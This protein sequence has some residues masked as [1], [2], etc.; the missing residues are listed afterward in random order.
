[1]SVPISTF[2]NELEKYWPKF[3]A[4]H[5]DAKWLDDDWLSMKRDM[6]RTCCV[7]VIDFAQNYAHEPRFEHQSNFFSQT[8][9]T[10]LPIVLRF[11]IEDLTN[12]DEARRAEMIAFCDK[13]ELPHV[14]V[15]THYVLSSDML[16]DSAIVQKAFDDHVFPY[17]KSVTSGIKTVCVRSD[18]CKAQFKC[19]AVQL[20]AVT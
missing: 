8:Q 4:H 9:T 2:V 13:N 7:A 10:I 5:N 20:R 14:V 12:I 1:V 16:H 18:G 19:V 3:I 15:E 11:R 17:V 6:P